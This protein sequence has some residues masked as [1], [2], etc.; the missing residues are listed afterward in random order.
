MNRQEHLIQILQ[1]EAAECIKVASKIQR[2]GADDID[3]HRPH[4]L[5]NATELWQEVC[6][7]IAV[8][9]MLVAAGVIANP[10]SFAGESLKAA[11]KAKV[12]EFLE[13]SRKRGT[14]TDDAPE[15]WWRCPNCRGFIISETNRR[16]QPEDAK[17][18]LCHDVACA[19]FDEIPAE[20]AL[21]LLN[22]GKEDG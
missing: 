17:C 5:P 21:R 1:E 7:F 9:E 13:Y 2:F 3:P 6:D 11:K 18:G 8:A 10:H 22:G 16:K 4:A 15:K 20:E 12:E 14:L 19:D